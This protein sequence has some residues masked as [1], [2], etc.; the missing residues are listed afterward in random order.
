MTVLPQLPPTSGQHLLNN[1]TNHM[2]FYNFCLFFVMLS[3]AR[4]RIYDNII[5][6][7]SEMICVLAFV[8]C[9]VSKKNQKF[10]KKRENIVDWKIKLKLIQF[11]HRYKEAFLAFMSIV[12]RLICIL[13]R[14]DDFINESS[15]DWLSSEKKAHF[16]SEL[17][18]AN[19]LHYIATSS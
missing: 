7:K 9:F 6:I 4:S 18:N 12:S 8:S 16:I 17:L 19:Q 13:L 15:M 2:Q 5:S 1:Y 11:C 10:G 3:S 14:A